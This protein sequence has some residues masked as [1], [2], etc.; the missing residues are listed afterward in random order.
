MQENNNVPVRDGQTDVPPHRLRRAAVHRH[1]IWPEEERRR[2]HCIILKRES[3]V[4]NNMDRKQGQSNSCDVIP[5]RQRCFFLKML[6]NNLFSQQTQKAASCSGQSLAAE[7][8]LVTSSVFPGTAHC[9]L[10]HSSRYRAPPG[11][12]ACPA[13]C[14]AWPWQQGS[15]HGFEQTG[16]GSER[17]SPH[18]RSR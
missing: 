12:W 6:Q 18:N 17:T 8:R 3:S 7:L 13:G 5:S 2:N 15:H 10:T 11:G 4:R 9:C 14:R 1:I 16:L